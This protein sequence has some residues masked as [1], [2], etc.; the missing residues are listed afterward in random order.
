MKDNISSGKE[1][2]AYLPVIFQRM[3]FSL[4]NAEFTLYVI[5]CFTFVNR[6]KNFHMKFYAYSFQILKMSIIFLLQRRIF[7][8]LLSQISP[9]PLFATALQHATQ[10]N[11]PLSHSVIRAY[12]FCLVL[13]SLLLICASND[14]RCVSS[15]FRDEYSLSTYLVCEMPDILGDKRFSM[16][17]KYCVQ[18]YIS[19]IAIIRLPLLLPYMKHDYFDTKCNE[20]KF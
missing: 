6:Q 2:F 17:T 7:L 12:V 11:F 20:K 4:W 3:T 13:V 10:G 16:N 15:P 18:H 5:N 8:A 19:V 1:D 14:R 9:L